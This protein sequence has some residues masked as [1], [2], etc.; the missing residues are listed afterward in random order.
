MVTE[1]WLLK[2]GKMGFSWVR[3][4][5]L[6]LAVVVLL[7][8]AGATAVVPPGGKLPAVSL[9]DLKGARH[10]LQD[11]TR[12]KV[13]L[14]VYWSISCP[15][16]RREMVNILELGRRFKGNPFVQIMINGDSP[17]MKAVAAAYAAQYKMP[18]PVL[19]DLGPQDSTPFSS[20]LDVVA[21]PTIVVADAKGRV[22]F[23][24]EG[25]VDLRAAEKAIEKA[26]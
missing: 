23:T 18:R 21:T 17:A 19:L 14:L 5:G 13:A 3:G 2:E 22:V 10:R 12:G 9:P 6:L 1:P 7:T 24:A 8:A 26:F 11:M 16:C 25:E 15:I 20:A 4:I